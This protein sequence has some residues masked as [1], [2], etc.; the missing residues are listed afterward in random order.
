MLDKIL[1]NK[2]PLFVA[3]GKS[4]QKLLTIKS[5]E[6]LRNS[7]D[8]FAQNMKQPNDTLFIFGHSL[9]DKDKHILDCI[10]KG[11][12]SRVY[13]DLF[14]DPDSDDHKKKKK[15]AKK[16]EASR[17]SLKVKFFQSE[18]AKVWG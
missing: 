13:V 17:K 12:I 4:K 9:E 3:E 6:Y 2:F 8:N 18:T 15:L 5:N 7:Y 14:G 1:S 11:T 16:L 10:T